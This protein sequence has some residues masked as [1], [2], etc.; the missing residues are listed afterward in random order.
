MRNRVHAIQLAHNARTQRSLSAHI[1]TSE[2][3]NAHV[4]KPLQCMCFDP[5]IETHTETIDDECGTETSYKN[6]IAESFVGAGFPVSIQF[7]RMLRLSL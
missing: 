6:G 3:I 5:N 1:I 2:E 7:K 4:F